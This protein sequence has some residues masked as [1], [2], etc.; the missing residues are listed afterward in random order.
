M[1]PHLNA[2]EITKWNLDVLKDWQRE[3]IEEIKKAYKEGMGRILD[4]VISENIKGLK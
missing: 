3:V 2:L 4:Q 1:E